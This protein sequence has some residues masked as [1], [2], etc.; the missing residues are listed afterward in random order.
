[1]VWKKRRREEDD[2]D[3]WK[4][5][6]FDDFFTFDIEKEFRRMEEWMNRIMR[7]FQSGEIKGPY[8]VNVGGNGVV[9][10]SLANIIAL[11]LAKKRR[12]WISFHKYSLLYLLITLGIF[13][14]LF[15]LH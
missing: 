2:E 4:R 1:M 12:I 10:A 13:Y 6:F 11:R 8:G 14:A 5:D 7:E 3:D 9:I 15:S